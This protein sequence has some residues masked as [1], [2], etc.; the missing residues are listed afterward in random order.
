MLNN[1]EKTAMMLA[2]EDNLKGKTVELLLIAEQK[3]R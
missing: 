2:S 3:E 1:E